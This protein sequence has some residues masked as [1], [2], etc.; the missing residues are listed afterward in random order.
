MQAWQQE[1]AAWPTAD[2]PGAAP[3]GDAALAGGQPPLRRDASRKEQPH[4]RADSPKE[5]EDTS[6]EAM[7]SLDRMA[8]RFPPIGH[9]P[10]QS[11]FDLR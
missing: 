1:M 4:S 9:R 2:Q 11:P 6:V 7:A 8:L 5:R 10:V 3:T